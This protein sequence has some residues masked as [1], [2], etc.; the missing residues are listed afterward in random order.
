MHARRLCF[1]VVAALWSLLA[2]LTGDAKEQQLPADGACEAF[3]ELDERA[4]DPA[5]V[6]NTG[7]LLFGDMAI[8][9][10]MTGLDVEKADLAAMANKCSTTLGR[11]DGTQFI[12]APAVDQYVAILRAA[13]DEYCEYTRLKIRSLKNPAILRTYAP[14]QACS[15]FVDAL[16]GKT[17][18][19]ELWRIQIHER[20]KDNIDPQRFLRTQLAHEQA[21]DFQKWVR[22]EVLV[23]GWHNCANRRTIR[24]SEE[25][26]IR[27]EAAEK[28]FAETFKLRFTN[29]EE[30]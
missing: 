23:F 22:N 5:A 28:Y 9:Y 15:R 24:N 12:R 17:D 7:Q 25:F 29:C 3:I 8:D 2:P 18:I 19:V 4:Y 14:A 27:R 21:P 30:D 10:P 26:R 6:I 11:L 1:S 20:A 13:V 16:E